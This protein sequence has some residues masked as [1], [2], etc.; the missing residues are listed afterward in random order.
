M[1]ILI[2]RYQNRKLYNTHTKRYITL[3]EIEDLI[4][5]QQEIQVIDNQTGN[6][7]TALTLSQVI[8]ETEKNHTGFLPTKL[9]TSLVQSGGSKIEDI[10]RNIFNSLS[11]FHHYDDEIKR[12]ILFLVENGEYTKEEGDRILEKLLAVSPQQ[13]TSE[14][15][16]H[17]ILELIN[18]RQVPTKKEL[19]LI[20]Q[21][22]DELSQRL[23]EFNSENN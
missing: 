11:L 8:F 21:K 14:E 23:D 6:D 12:R 7:I 2:K 5:E 22:I 10:R 1:P 17:R 19:K 20:T 18:V 15:L 16:E 9:L 3:D 4:K 13:E